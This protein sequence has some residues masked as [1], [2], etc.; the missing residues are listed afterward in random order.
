MTKIIE[1]EIYHTLN[2]Y[3]K[4]QKSFVTI[5]TFDGV[6]LGHQKILKKLIQNAKDTNC[7]SV[8][9][10]FFPHPQLVLN[11]NSPIKMLNTI[12]E[13]ADLLQK[14][15]LDT[16]IIHPFDKEFSELSAEDFIE[17]IVVKK[18]N[19]QKIIIGHDHR[20]GKNRSA[21]FDDLVVFGQ[22]YNFE[23]EQI[24]VEEQSNVA[25]SSTKIRN[26][27][28]K[29]NF[30]I[31][32]KYLGYPYFFSGLVVS[33]KKLG[34]TINFPT[35]NIQIAQNY[36]LI[37]NSGVYV[38]RCELNQGIFFGM[39]NIG[40][41]PTFNGTNQTIEVHLFDFDDAIYNQKI[42]VSVLYFLRDEQKFG[43]IEALKLQLQNDKS[44][45]LLILNK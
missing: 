4:T 31:A 35:A 37:P 1:L 41:R 26:A 20:F 8:V 24:S 10:T 23:V 25:I 5:G 11:E 6:H 15:N 7:I 22:K 14:L 9:L 33:G 43:S 44:K 17:Q 12:D 28:L 39:M 32:E 3:S 42:K 29:N 27:I 19:V 13:K 30:E 16:L 2:D 18:L 38:V 40:N 45:A 34:R 21:S 36:K